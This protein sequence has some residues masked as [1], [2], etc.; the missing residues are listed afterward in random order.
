MKY[1]IIF[2]TLAAIFTFPSPGFCE[3]DAYGVAP[4]RFWMPNQSGGFVCQNIPAT[5]LLPKAQSIALILKDQEDRIAKLENIIAEL[6][7]SSKKQNH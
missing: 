5:V 2:F 6:M 4:C 3:F 1:G 7:A